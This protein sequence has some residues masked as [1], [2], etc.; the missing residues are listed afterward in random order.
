LLIG[1]LDSSI[2]WG[3]P[4]DGYQ[5]FVQK[6]EGKAITSDVGANQNNSKIDEATGSIGQEGTGRP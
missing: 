1:L 3:R 4:K 5:P 6:Q 2:R